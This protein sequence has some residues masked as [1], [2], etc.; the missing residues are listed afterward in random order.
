MQALQ[1]LLPVRPARAADDDEA[2]GLGTRLEQL[3][4]GFDRHICALE[5]LDSPYEEEQPTAE[6]QPER[7]A[8]LRPVPGPEERVVD[9]GWHDADASG[10]AT[11]ERRDLLGLHTARRQDRVGALDDGRLG[12]GAPVRHVGLDLFRYRLGLHAIEGVEGAHQ[13]QVQLVFDHM[14]RKPRKPVIGMHRRV[15]QALAA[16]AA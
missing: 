6:R 9:A 8:R 7:A 14:A 2:I 16:V 4:Q 5:R 10:L 3:G 12:L 13:R 11:V 1:R 15:R